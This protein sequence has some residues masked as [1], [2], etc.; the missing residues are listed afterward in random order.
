M[1]GYLCELL[2]TVGCKVIEWCCYDFQVIVSL[3]DINGQ[4]PRFVRGL[5]QDRFRGYKLIGVGFTLYKNCEFELK[6]NP[7]KNKCRI[8]KKECNTEYHYC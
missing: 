4:I 2:S 7:T 8:Q 1:S 6:A 5:V 3:Y